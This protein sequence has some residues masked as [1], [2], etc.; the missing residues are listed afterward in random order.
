MRQTDRLFGQLGENYELINLELSAIAE[1][2]GSVDEQMSAAEVATQRL[3][4]LDDK[5]LDT[6]EQ[7]NEAGTRAMNLA[8]EIQM[9]AL[10]AAIEAARAG[11][12]GAGF[13]LLAERVG[14]LARETAKG[15]HDL[16]Q[17]LR[18]LKQGEERSTELLSRLEN[19]LGRG[20][21]EGEELRAALTRASS[22]VA[23]QQVDLEELGTN[24]EARV[25]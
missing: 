21:G 16:K 13:S 18:E 2:S 7:L 11:E 17:K 22:T 8:E 19:A 14:A 15:I 9:L 24:E 1:R 25:Y 23:K 20:R 6:R 5:A 12:A 4:K 3:I 10:N